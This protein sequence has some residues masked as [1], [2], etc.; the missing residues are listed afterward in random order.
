MFRHFYQGLSRIGRPR[1]FAIRRAKRRRGWTLER[2]EPR[3]LLTVN[4][5]GFHNDLG[6]TGANTGETALTPADVKPNASF[7]K[8]FTTNVDGQVYSQPLVDTAVTI[9]AGPNTTTGAAGLHDVVYVATEHDSLYAI[10]SH[11]G[12]ILWTR[13][14]LTLADGLPGA[15]S[16]TTVPNAVLDSTDITPE[17][18]ITGTPVI[19]PA[20][21]AL[22][23]V[24]KTAE[25]VSGTVH[26]VQR[27]HAISL[28]DGTDITTPYLIGDT[29]GTN[30]NNTQIYVYGTGSGEV[31]DPYNGT[32]NQVVQFNALREN[33]RGALTFENNT[34][35]VDWAS[36]GDNGPYHGWVVAWDVS[37][38]AT[39]GLTVKGVL[40]D[41]PNGSEG[42]IWQ[43]GGRL[44]FEADGSAFY[45]ETGN[46]PGSHAATTLN[47]AGF[48]SDGSYY[49]ALV[50]VEAD[51]TTSPTNQNINGWGLKVVD[52][53]IPYN[54]NALDSADQ[55]F[56]SGAP[57]L[58][59]DS[60][61]I[62]GHPHLMIAG[63]K[64]GEIYLI[65][66][67]NMGHFDPTADHVVDAV[68]NASGTLTAPQL[69]NGLLS[70][71]AYFNGHVY[72]VSG[73]GSVAK[74]IAI[75]SN[76]T[77]TAIS[78]TTNSFGSLPGSPSISASGSTNG[79]VWIVDRLNNEL[80]A[81]DAT[82][83][84]TELWNSNDKAGGAD[85]V[86]AIVKFAPPTVANGEVFVGTTSSL[87]AYGLQPPSSTIPLAPVLSGTPLSGSSIDLTWTDASVAPNQAS[88][89]FIEESTDDVNFTQVTTAPAAAK[90]IALGGLSPQ[91]TYDFRIRGFNA[92]GDSPYSNTVAVT[93]TN[94]V[95]A[96]D[97]SGGFDDAAGTITLNGSAK[98]NDDDLEVTDGGG[99]EA[100]S[101]FYTS[102]VNITQFT[103]QFTFQLTNGANTSDGFTFTIQ[104]VSPTALGS[105]GG[106]LGY[107]ATGTGAKILESVAIKFDL[108][109]NAGEGND[110]T[111]LY[112]DGAPPTNVGSI[113]LTN[114]G[115]NLHSGDPTLVKLM[116]DGAALTVTMTDMDTNAPA[117]QTYTV[118]IP[119]FVGGSSAF[120]GFTGGTGS[121]SVTTNIVNWIFS[122]AA[123]QAP[124]APSGLG[125]QAA[126]ATSVALTW[127]NNATNQSAFIL[128]RATDAGFT[129]NLLTQNLPASPDSFTDTATGLNPGGT[130]FYRIRA[131]NS[132]G[133]SA[134]SASVS[135]SIPVA[136]PT[137]TNAQ[138]TAVS[139]TEID[140]GWTDNAGRGADDYLILRSVSGG[141]F[142]SYATL[143]ALNAL[144]PSTYTWSDTNVAPGTSYEY[145]IEAVNV[146][147]HNDFTGADAT[148][149]TLPPSSL[150]ATAT[151]G[152]VNLSW[153]APTGA[154]SYNVYRGTASGSETLLQ[155][156]VTTTSYTD[157]TGTVGTTYFYTVTAVNNNVNHVPVLPAESGASNEVSATPLSTATG[158]APIDFSGGFAGANGIVT[159]NGSAALNGAK[160]ELTNGRAL[161]AG[162][163][164]ATAAIDITKFVTS[165]T[166][167]TTAGT[168]TA[169]G[170]TFTIQGVGPK[171]LGSRGGGLGYSAATNGTGTKI[172]QSVAIKFDLYGN[173][174]EGPDS[175]GLYTNGALPTNAGSID[176]T[177]TGINLHN[178][179]PVQ[180]T[181]AYNGTTLTVTLTD[182]V[183]NKTAT[184]TYAVNIPSFIGGTTA[185]VG[186]TGGTGAATSTQDILNWTYLTAPAPPS[187]L[188]AQVVSAVSV[189]VTWTNNATDQ[190]GF[191]LDRATNPGFT[192]NLVTQSLPGTANAF[193]DTAAGLVPGGTYYYQIRATNA[194][195]ASANSVS[196]SVTIP[197]P[198]ASAT[199]A[200]VTKVSTSE[201]DLSW[202]DNAG[203][204][205][206]GYLIE[207]SVAGGP[208][209]NYATL[210]ASSNPAPSTYVWSDTSVIP[211]TAYDY[212]IIAFNLSGNSNFADAN[213]TTLTLAPTGLTA[214]AAIG[215]VTLAWSAPT[216]AISYNVYHGAASGAETLLHSGVTATTFT[217]STGTAGTNYF[218][219]VTA[220]N[221]NASLAPPL[222]AESAA[223][224]EV[225][226]TPLAP[227][228]L[229]FSAGFAGSTSKLTYNG[230]AAIN[231]TKLELT[232]GKALEAGSAFTTSSINIT[233]FT[234][235]FTFQTTA[236]ANTADGFTFTIQGIGPTA[237]GSRGGGLGYST[238]TNGTGTKIGQ[239][240]AIKF[241][242]YGN[243]GE[244][245]DSTGLYTNGALPTNAGSINL[246]P[247]GIDLHSGDV[248][249]V[250][251]T[252]D[253]TTLTVTLTDTVTKATATQTY[254][255]NIPSL[256]GGSAGYVG[257]TGGTGAVTSTQDILNWTFTP[258]VG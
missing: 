167:Q 11:T 155:G 237:L 111:G 246:T 67:D 1:A 232:N 133:D 224:N 54:Q 126:S 235:Q 16:V 211:G 4:I 207:R 87:V 121:N 104:G 84:G 196:A 180:A 164:F 48:P 194:A 109:S 218:Y 129:Q 181:L 17:V 116:Y 25:T 248:F 249:L 31:T 251:M 51:P 220:L 39:Q 95:S 138:V 240:V 221:N 166:F 215:S 15:T 156:G 214:T 192:Q 57:T 32:K 190:T 96:I 60:A 159:L 170:F 172:G 29:T 169:D 123:A 41:D 103:S 89:Y 22:Y 74:E 191:Q 223:S 72:I 70:T 107:G 83:L 81:Y 178:G 188:A 23:V 160:L 241:D 43:G 19:D 55:D 231:G 210:S 131:T 148:T 65:D 7:G 204:N 163:A 36:H 115:I 139:S 197:L 98:L 195:G 79:I 113:D 253:G 110:S 114:T 6:S 56:G 255:V 226:A 92:I 145:H 168:N 162:S 189:N 242:L 118:N 52:Y 152:A 153:T 3:W 193:T 93:T 5:L 175:T 68:P 50:K 71:A 53:F 216:G 174:D 38:L 257:F 30:T 58:L 125:A 124:A 213:A 212:H 47:A 134:N 13:N 203:Q 120:V 244:G 208:F 62:A 137:P 229:D 199:N 64:Q 201:I 108:F 202:T 171:A 143:P 45:F 258:G 119:S 227:P 63:G 112:T 44:A 233:K 136:P 250:T 80:H 209:A 91:T 217:D 206:T 105:R 144:P 66:R 12:A 176:L 150:A 49:D 37:N 21:N 128:D 225:S 158:S 106:G 46:G 130:Y 219:T 230:S 76:G 100:G 183:T 20:N 42:G 222:P 228:A 161:E 252:Y 97:F 173:S 177:P 186:F 69:V 254:T 245:P 117:T 99:S 85:A 26:Y 61:G 10:D 94:Q 86:G 243:S 9:A 185:F 2:L 78:Q 187:A 40:N 200:V 34:V 27:L 101:A 151:V 234:T 149:I 88:G 82:S 132:A 33:Q 165:F 35:Y 8:M 127:T 73:Y 238:A 247:S 157:S 142:T 182:T 198:P 154:I 141:A 59:P 90:G 147:G 122:P 102:P 146:S 18:G 205:A 75:N 14:F 24:T 239:S 140:L 179:N 184:Q 236:G 77:L 256:V 135:I 28:S